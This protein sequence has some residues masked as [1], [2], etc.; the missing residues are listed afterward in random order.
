MDNVYEGIFIPSHRIVDADSKLSASKSLSNWEYAALPAEEW[1][2]KLDA[3]Q[4]IQPSKFN[5]KEDGTYTHAIQNW[6]HTQFVC[7]DGDNIKGV[8]F[9]DDGT[10]KNPNG[11][12]AWTEHGLLSVK[13]PQLLN[14]IYAAGESVSSMLTEPLHRRYRL[15]FLFDKPITSE[16]HYRHILLQLAERFPI[17]PAVSRS[18][19]QPVFGNGR[20]EFN[21]HICGKTLKLDDFPMPQKQEL[22]QTN[23]HNNKRPDESLEDFLRRH[24][25]AY[26]QTKDP[27]KFYVECPYKDGHTGGKQGPTDSYVF[28]DGKAWSYYCSHAH[29]ANKRTWEAFKEGN[30][31]RPAYNGNG[32]HP[33]RTPDPEEI[34]QSNEP[35]MHVP[36]PEEM[37]FGIFETY[38][39]SLEGRIPVPD[40]FAFGSLKHILSA[41]LGRRI[42]LESQPRVFPNVYTGLIGESSKGIKGVSLGVIRDLIQ[43]A[44]PNVLVLTKTATEEGLI[45]LFRT[46][47]SKTGTDD[48]GEKYEYYVNG[49]A[50]FL[51]TEK[52]EQII[53]NTDSHE[54]IRVLGAFEELSAILNR[55]KKV[56]F[57]GMIELFME[58]YDMPNEIL[59]A[60]K[61][62]KSK[63]DFP[64]FTMMGASAFELIEESLS[65]HFISGG[66][67]NRIEWYLGEEKEPIFLYKTA[68]VDL[69]TEA[70]N[71]I[72][73][74]R[75]SYVVGQSFTINDDAYE[76]GDKWNKEFTEQH[77]SI[78]NLLVA[79]SM[80][81]M[82]IFVLKN[83]LIFAALEHR[84]DFQIQYE[85]IA[86]AIRLSEYNCTVV[87]RLFGNFA[88]SEHQKVCNRIVEILKR[89]P[90]L[91]AKQ[92]QNKMRWADPK[93]I[94]LGLD[95]MKQMNMIGFTKP[96]RAILY[97][98]TKLNEN[99]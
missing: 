91:S 35:E 78:D 68:E 79:G 80:R 23:G 22:P 83:A 39:D 87:E 89:E 81:R 9:L 17:I 95:I 93:E 92:I 72:Q 7:A 44:D 63:I 99:E 90:M 21:F 19:A 46:P 47:E 16:A 20:E 70:V 27:G 14:E 77:K 34:D 45:D 62:Q 60:N 1:I 6:V 12:E 98:V 50:E 53:D 52:V 31:I 69:W 10:D 88:K 24:G 61:Q 4:T 15:I 40:A 94:H 8:E 13:Y 38:R 86:N 43:K 82:K 56:T 42:H 18:P 33:K 71:E 51:S 59:V 75:D 26:T 74:L 84:G 76:L 5:P 2:K 55:T 48:E 85:D 66:F 36:F 58:L 64:T 97:Y 54:S 49:I 65:Q 28:D 73:K 37:F 3:G 67:T 30:N 25:V 32:N 29:C 57:G 11:I 41:S 96:K